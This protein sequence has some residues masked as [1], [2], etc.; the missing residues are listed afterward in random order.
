MQKITAVMTSCGRYDLLRRTIKSLDNLEQK[1]NIIIF[2]D[3]DNDEIEHSTDAF[4]STVASKKHL[5]SMIH[6][7]GVFRKG[8]HAALEF[9]IS[10]VTLDTKYVL[11][12]EDDWEF[13]NSYDWIS[14]SIQIME[15][16]P[17]I[18]KVLARYNSPHPCIHSHMSP[19]GHAYGTLAPWVGN[20]GI[21]W[22]GFSWNPGVTRIDLLRNFVPF[23]KWEQ[24]LSENIYKAG[25]KVAEISP[26]YTHI[27]DGR[28]THE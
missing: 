13:N 8:Q 2:D 10:Q 19:S 15:A 17:Q 6:P 28:S 9:L 20:D 25:Y 16:D 21:L 11:F 18:I 12:L 4:F 26:V 27:G 5:I 14:E 1:L 3:V 23:P 7:V 22:H 24:E